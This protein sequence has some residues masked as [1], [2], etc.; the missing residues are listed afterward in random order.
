MTCATTVAC[1]DHRSSTLASALAAAV[2]G[3]FADRVERR[4]GTTTLLGAIGV[5]PVAGYLGLAFAGVAGGLVA[6]LTFFVARGLGLVVLRNA[7]NSR[8]PSRFRATA[9]SLASFGFRGSFVITGPV[10]GWA[11]DLWGMRTTLELLALG[12]AVIVLAILVPLILAVRAA[13]TGADAAVS[14]G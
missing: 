14:P 7:F 2:A 12:S 6:A 5:L 1:I 10:V 8:V 3:Q 9:N 4:V 11:F 13:R